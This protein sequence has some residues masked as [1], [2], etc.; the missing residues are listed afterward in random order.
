MAVAKLVMQCWKEDYD[1]ILENSGI[2]ELLSG[3]YVDDGR[4]YHRKLKWG[5]R[6]CENL[7][8][9]TVDEDSEKDDRENEVDRDQLTKREVLKAM[10]SVNG[11]LTFTMELCSDFKDLKLPSLQFFHR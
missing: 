7:R 4:S 1:K 6:Y 3:L 9:F 11:D 8:K 5:E 2:D 10:N